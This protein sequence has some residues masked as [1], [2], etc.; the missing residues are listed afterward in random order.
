MSPQKQTPPE[1]WKALS[2]KIRRDLLTFIGERESV[3]FTEIQ[4]QFEMKVGTLYHHLDT[5][6]DLIA[7][8][9]QKKYL[10]TLK[11][12]KAY[13]LIEEELD[14]IAKERPS[15]GAFTFLHYIFLRPVFKF[16]EKD[17]L[18]S[19]GLVLFFFTG[20]GVVTYFISTTPILLFPSYIS[21]S[22]VAPIIFVVST[23]VTYL[24]I[25]LFSSIFFKKRENKL[26]LLQGIMLAQLPLMLFSILEA[27]VLDL[28]Y[29]TSPLGLDLWMF[30]LLIFIQIIYLGLIIEVLIVTKEI[31]ME[32]A[33]LIALFVI[34]LLNTLSFLVLRGL[35]IEI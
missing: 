6:G 3:S 15:Y 26:A 14:V 27:L 21:P 16:I 9:S 33:G 4:S 2:N 19:L 13:Q 25:E 31:R 10:L 34:Y 1:I 28:T 20:L 24:L 23:L 11:G 35:V 17:S 8:D 5:L 32:K 29:P 7:Q 22:F 30:I 12:H 18:R